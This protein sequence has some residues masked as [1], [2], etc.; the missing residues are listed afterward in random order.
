L[1]REHLDPMIV[2]PRPVLELGSTE[3]VKRAVAAGLG[4]SVV[5]G[6]TV[7]REMRNQELVVRPLD[8]ALAKPLRFVRRDDVAA[9]H[10][11]VEFLRTAAAAT[12]R[13]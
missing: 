9:S 11:F 8:P 5:L 2:L 12:N 10:P 7:V 1:I 13:K 4:V 6:L 3:A